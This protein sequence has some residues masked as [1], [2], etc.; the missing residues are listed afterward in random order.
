MIQRFFFNGVNMTGNDLVI[1]QG[2]KAAALVFPDTANPPATFFNKTP[3]AA[4]MTLNRLV[5]LW[6]IQ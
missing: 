2:F 4:Q 6:L 3:V 1:H 5:F